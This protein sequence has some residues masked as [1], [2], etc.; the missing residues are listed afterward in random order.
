MKNT[1]IFVHKDATLQIDQESRKY[2][3]DRFSNHITG[4]PV[5]PLMDCHIKIKKSC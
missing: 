1:D 5:K 4:K 2:H 3:D